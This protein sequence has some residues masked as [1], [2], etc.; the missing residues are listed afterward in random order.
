MVSKPLVARIVHRC[1]IALSSQRWWQYHGL[2]I[3]YLASL[4]SFLCRLLPCFSFFTGTFTSRL[5]H[6]FFLTNP[7]N[8]PSDT[9]PSFLQPFRGLSCFLITELIRL[10]FVI[11]VSHGLGNTNT[12]S[13]H[14]HLNHLWLHAIVDG[15]FIF[16]HPSPFQPFLHYHGQEESSSSDLT[17]DTSASWTRTRLSALQS[18][19]LCLSNTC[20]LFSLPP[21][22]RFQAASSSQPA[23]PL[24][25]SQ[26][27]PWCFPPEDLA[28]SHFFTSEEVA[29]FPVSCKQVFFVTLLCP[30]WSV[31]QCLV[32]IRIR[33]P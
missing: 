16:R 27:P 8:F 21:S 19:A 7:R 10:L 3:L 18:C 12:L 15:C 25:S 30:K 1:C 4:F 17:W 23:A 28:Y 14:K 31:L 26:V 32:C 11:K 13:L 33:P 22:H 29:R 5:S 9:L 6:K 2:P 24:L 20:C